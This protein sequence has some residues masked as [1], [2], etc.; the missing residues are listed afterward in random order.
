MEKSKTRKMQLL[1]LTLIVSIFALGGSL[2]AALAAE[3]VWDRTLRKMVEA[4]RYGGTLT[5]ANNGE[6]TNSDPSIGGADVGFVTSGGLE[7]LSIADWAIDRKVNNLRNEY[8]ADDHLAPALAA[9]WE[10]PDPLTYIFHIRQGVRWHKKA[11]MNGRE[12]TAQDV[13]YNYHRLTGTGSFSKPPGVVEMLPKLEYESIQATDKYTVVIKLKK[14]R[15]DALRVLVEDPYAFM[16]PP[17]L[18]KQD[19]GTAD[20]R[21]LVGTGPLMLTDWLEGSSVTWEKNPDYWGVDEK[22]PQNR[23]PYIDTLKSLTMPE[24]TAR[25]AAIRSGKVDYIGAQARSALKVPDMV[26]SLQRTNPDLKVYPYYFRSSAVQAYDL[27]KPPFNDIRVRKTLQLALD[28]ETVNKTYYKGSAVVTPQG[29]IGNF[30]TTFAIH[31]D[32]WPE[33]IKA[34]YRYDPK[35]AE[36]LLD[37]AGYPRGGDGIR[38]ATTINGNDTNSFNQDYWAIVQE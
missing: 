18:I 22:F 2:T 28:L 27:T 10:N 38:F 19:G 26:E 37:E 12:L 24:E 17:E 16:A 8:L 32:Q 4:P 20:W 5:I 30:Q 25:I 31:Y 13:E 14:P 36:K 29:L 21:K 3:M 33:E 23:L 1:L 15:L 9:G 34:G 35:A 6:P 7:K 11:P